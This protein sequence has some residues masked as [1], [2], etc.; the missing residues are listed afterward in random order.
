MIVIPKF[1]GKVGIPESFVKVTTYYV[2]TN[3]IKKMNLE[4][5]PTDIKTKF[6]KITNRLN[7]LL[8]KPT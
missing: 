4:E 1:N 8:K 6:D 7:K 2:Q 3:S 5:K